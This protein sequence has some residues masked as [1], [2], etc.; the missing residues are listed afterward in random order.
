MMP[1]KNPL[2]NNQEVT[3]ATLLE[4]AHCSFHRVI[5][6]NG[7]E[8]FGHKFRDFHQSFLS[9]MSLMPLTVCIGSS[10]E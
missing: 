9:P 5:R 7:K 2:A 8:T 4:Q 10:V 3:N 6:R 1:T